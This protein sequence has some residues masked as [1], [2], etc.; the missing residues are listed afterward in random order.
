MKMR[1]ILIYIL[2]ITI[3]AATSVLPVQAHGLIYETKKL[4]DNKMRITLKW[5]NPKEAR[6]IV[7]SYYYL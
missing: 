2:I 3:I 5:S 1:K 4:D 6:G 7:I